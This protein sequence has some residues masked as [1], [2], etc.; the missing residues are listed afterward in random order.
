MSKAG[1]SFSAHY[2]FS[3][4]SF[5]FDSRADSGCWCGASAGRSTDAFFSAFLA[6]RAEGFA[7]TGTS[8]LRLRSHETLCAI[9]RNS[10]AKGP[11]TPSGLS[12]GPP[13]TRRHLQSLGQPL[14]RPQHRDHRPSSTVFTRS[15][16]AGP[17]SPGTA[18]PV[19]HQLGCVSR[20]PIACQKHK[21]G[22]TKTY[23]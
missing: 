14:G 3:R 1:S 2:F 7:V 18:E 5:G 22:R 9:L 8:G 4:E 19:R 17:Q 11:V 21:L 6:K 10:F 16:R 23:V 12:L 15:P 20:K 13:L